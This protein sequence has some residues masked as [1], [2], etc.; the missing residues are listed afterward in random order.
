MLSARFVWYELMTSDIDASL[1]FYSRVI[2]WTTHDHPGGGERYAIVNANGAGIG[3]V[4]RL[5]AGLTHPMWIGYIGT[6][7][8]EATVAKFTEAGGHVRKGP[9]QIPGVGHIAMVADQQQVGLAFIQPEGQGES[10]AF[11]QA[12]PGHGNWHE[13]HTPDPEASLAFYTAQFGWQKGETHDMGPAG[14]YQIFKSDG[15]DIGG[16]VKSSL[17]GPTWIYYFGHASISKAAQDVREAGGTVLH[18]PSP[19]P[20][21]AHIL[22]AR[23]PQGAPFAVVGPA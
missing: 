10:H 21:G 4:M 9:W 23:D 2:G 5:P 13:L 19:I 20:G 8:I 16:I 22:M 11:D 6:P 18:G 12:K 17:F 1:A 3:G 14:I 7:D 15:N